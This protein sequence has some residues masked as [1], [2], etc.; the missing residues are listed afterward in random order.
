MVQFVD[1][2]NSKVVAKSNVRRQAIKCSLNKIQPKSQTWMGGNIK[3]FLD[4]AVEKE[5]MV[6]VVAE[7]NNRVYRVELT[8]S[9]K[10]GI[11]NISEQLKYY[12]GYGQK[13]IVKTPFL[14]KNNLLSFV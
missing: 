14:G 3:K 4:L 6:K 5:G 1:Y 9:T 13:D 7:E 8:R 12:S 2:G 10:T 11:M